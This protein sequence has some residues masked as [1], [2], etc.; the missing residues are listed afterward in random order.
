MLSFASKVPRPEMISCAPSGFTLKD[1]VGEKGGGAKEFNFEL[2]M[3]GHFKE[4]L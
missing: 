4:A 3:G 1:M 2:G